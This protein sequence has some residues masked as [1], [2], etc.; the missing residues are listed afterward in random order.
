MINALWTSATGM[1]AQQFNIDT[2]ANNLANVNTTGFKKA[3]VEFQDLLYQT[4][5]TPG[6]QSTQDSIIPVGIQLGHGVRPAA[7]QRMF[8]L[9][10]VVETKN[11]FDIKLDSPYSFFKVVDDKQNF[12]YTRDGSFKLD[13]Q[14]QLVTSDGFSLDPAITIPAES[15]AEITIGSDGTISVR[16]DGQAE[17]QQTGQVTIYRFANPSG[18]QSVGQNFYRATVASGVEQIDQFGTMTSGFLEISN[19]EV[20]EEMVRLITGQRAY[21]ANSRA[22]M[23]SDDMLSTANQIRR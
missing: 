20:V 8:S 12:L 9:G 13:D 1:R 4:I 16:E 3:R 18:L 7:T 14:G 21:E 17:P 2:I 5:R 23:A 19:V 10:N 11:V 15:A 6:A 22:I